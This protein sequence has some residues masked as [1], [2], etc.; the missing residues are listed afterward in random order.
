MECL[1]HIQLDEEVED[2]LIWKSTPSGHYTPNS[3]CELAIGSIGSEEVLW[4]EMW[5][6]LAPPKVEVF[7]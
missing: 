4:R 3:F 6:G 2:K 1:N 5:A 7:V